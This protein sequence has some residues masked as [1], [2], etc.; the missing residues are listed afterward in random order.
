MIGMRDGH[1]RA[2]E[3]LDAV[4]KSHVEFLRGLEMYCESE[5]FFFCHAGVDPDVPVEVGKN[6]TFDLLWRRDHLYAENPV[7]EK[8]V[9]FGH[10][11]TEEV[12][13]TE[14]HVAIDTGLYAYGT[15]SAVDVLSGQVFQVRREVRG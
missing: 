13:I 3:I 5:R 1:R 10:T 4:P 2:A 12:V 9:V 11:P 14:K 15:L 6:N 7:W 8:T